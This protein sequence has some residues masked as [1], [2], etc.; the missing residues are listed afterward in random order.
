MSLLPRSRDSCKYDKLLLIVIS[1]T[2]YL[3]YPFVQSGQLHGQYSVVQ[4]KLILEFSNALENI[5][6]FGIGYMKPK[7]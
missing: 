3:E 5:L 2:L 4:M 1:I 6:D 7:E